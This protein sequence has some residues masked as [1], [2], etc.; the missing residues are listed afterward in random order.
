MSGILLEH[1]EIS[2]TRFCPQEAH[3][4]MGEIRKD[5]KIM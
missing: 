3:N 1:K 2:K 5:A 4:I